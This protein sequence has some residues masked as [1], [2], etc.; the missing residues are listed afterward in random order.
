MLIILTFKLYVQTGNI[1]VFGLHLFS[2]QVSHHNQ[3]SIIQLNSFSFIVVENELEKSKF[4]LQS[5]FVLSQL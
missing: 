3:K 5:S 1:T 2:S 4:T